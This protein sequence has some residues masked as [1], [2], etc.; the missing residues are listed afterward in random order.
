MEVRESV[1]AATG[2][3]MEVD[4]VTGEA[5]SGGGAAVKVRGPWSTAE[6]GILTELVCKFGA[7]NWSMIASGIPGRSGKSCR[8]RWCNQLN[9]HLKRKPFTDEEDR[10]IIEAHKIHGNKWAAIAKI[11]PGR[12]DNAI[13][14]HWNSTLRRMNVKSKPESGWECTTE[15]MRTS[16]EAT[17]SG[18]ALTSFKASEEMDM[19]SMKNL[20]KQSEVEA[21]T[22]KN[23]P[24]KQPPPFISHGASISLRCSE[25]VESTM[26]ENEPKQ[27]K[28]IAQTTKSSRVP[29]K[30]SIPKAISHSTE[31]NHLKGSHPVQKIGAFTV[32]NSSRRESTFSR[33]VPLQGSLLQ[34]SKP[35]YGIL[36]FLDSK[37]DEPFIPLHC[38]HGCCEASSSEHSSHSSLLGPEFMDYEDSSNLSSPNLTSLATDLTSISSIR[39]GLENVGEVR[40]LASDQIVKGPLCV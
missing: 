30:P 8:L 15:L 34:V 23:C 33:T 14:N 28:D 4:V 19:W 37:F 17:S 38:G 13:K 3:A 31:G 7:R 5:E 9:P 39:R 6:D 27:F 11:L 16:S 12:T 18:I 36:K 25:T 20:P 2:G 32:F 29:E 1:E 10:L 21:E 40:A 24:L 26:M 22:T 35:E